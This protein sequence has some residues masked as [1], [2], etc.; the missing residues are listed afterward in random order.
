[1][2]I[3]RPQF[4]ATLVEQFALHGGIDAAS[5]VA[6]ALAVIATEAPALL[7]IDDEAGQ[8]PLVLAQARS[9]GFRGKA[10]AVTDVPHAALA[11]FEHV[12]TRP[13]RFA[14]LLACVASLLAQ[15]QTVSLGGFVFRV[16]FGDLIDPGGRRTS[17]TEKE[18]AILSALAR[19][20]G[21]TIAKDKLLRDIWGYRETVTTHTLESHIYRLRHK[22]ERDQPAR[23]LIVSE[24]GG[25]RLLC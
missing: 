2:I 23:R 1:M 3:G 11:P 18:A 9:R 17:L 21:A 12:A 10:I 25:Y 24:D 22:I 6:A 7:I 15:P 19:A 4:C 16:E 14:E 13:L 5:Q 20:Q 8:A